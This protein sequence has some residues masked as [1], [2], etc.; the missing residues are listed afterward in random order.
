[1]ASESFDV[2]VIGTGAAGGVW[3]DACTRAG[4]EVVALERGPLLEPADFARHDEW[5]NT[6]RSD[7]FAPQWRDTLREDSNEVARPGR[8]ASLAQC[9]GGGTAHWGAVC[10]RMREDEFRVLSKEGPV[11]G[12]NLADWPIGYDELAPFYDR[13]EKRLGLAGQAGSNPFEPK[14]T[15]AYP[16]PAHPP[17]SATLALVQGAETLGRHP[18]PTPLAVNLA[19]A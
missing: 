10:W 17:R 7:G 6:H 1:M 4:L 2:C 8:S 5:S 9:V 14:R 12:A 11:E 3:I 18:F 19:A 15:Q 16:N 13:A